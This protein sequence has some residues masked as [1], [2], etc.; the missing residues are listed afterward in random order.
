MAKANGKTG[1]TGKAIQ[2]TLGGVGLD[3]VD[4]LETRRVLQE[5]VASVAGAARF[6]IAAA[7]DML[8]GKLTAQEAT[9]INTTSGRILKAA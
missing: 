4:G 3:S 5:G 8:S 7:A 1:E 9:V 2:Q 6:S